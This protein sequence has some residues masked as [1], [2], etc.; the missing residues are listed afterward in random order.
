MEQAKSL[1][2]VVPPFWHTEVANQLGL[3]R[4]AQKISE[5]ELAMALELIDDLALTTDRHIALTPENILDVMT[6]YQLTAYDAVYLELAV[7]LKLPLATFDRELIA[8]APHAGVS[9]VL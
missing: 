9:L 7:R 4:R 8:A 6:R 2:A 1:G 3:K 5:A